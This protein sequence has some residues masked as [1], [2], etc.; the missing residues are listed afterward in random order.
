MPRESLRVLID[1]LEPQLRDAFLAAVRDIQ[2]RAQI[3]LIE[4]ALR[5][6][7]VAGAIRAIGIDA[8]AFEVFD[9]AIESAYIA[10]GVAATEAMPAIPDPFGP[11]RLIARFDGRN[12]RAE[13]WLRSH[14]S[15]LITPP[16]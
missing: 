2:S 12:P 6:G 13:S 16:S 7:D 3:A 8:K 14:S 15:T 9:R 1:R 4:S 5:E 11:G 10:G